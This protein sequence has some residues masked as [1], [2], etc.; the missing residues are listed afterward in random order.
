MWCS[1]N[2]LVD[3]ILP[4]DEPYKLVHTEFMKMC[5]L[6]TQVLVPKVLPPP[7]I[8]PTVLALPA[9]FTTA[10][11]AP[12]TTTVAKTTNTPT[13]IPAMP[14]SFA[15]LAP[16]SFAVQ[17]PAPTPIPASSVATPINKELLVAK[18]QQLKQQM[19]ELQEFC[20]AVIEQS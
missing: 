7:S 5:K 15:P 4:I 2:F 10:T 20:M 17:Q 3:F 13:L 12:F 6:K 9:T 14:S 1:S 19:A 8:A 11:A 18:M 16:S